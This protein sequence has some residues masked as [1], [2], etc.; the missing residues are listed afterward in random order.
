MHDADQGFAVRS[1][2][3]PFHAAIG[4][5][6]LPCGI[7]DTAY[8]TRHRCGQIGRQVEGADALTGHA[9]KLVN[10][11][12]VFVRNKHATTIVGDT[13]AFRIEAAIGGIAGALAGVKIIG[14]TGKIE[15]AGRVAL[16][17]A[18]AQAKCRTRAIHQRRAAR[19]QGRALQRR[20]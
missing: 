12:A 10:V 8:G 18:V 20:R 15:L 13:N 5:P 17:R 4:D 11:R 7:F 1:D 2:G 3:Q 6:A 16:R 9:V 14:T 19:Q